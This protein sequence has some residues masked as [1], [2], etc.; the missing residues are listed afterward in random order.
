MPVRSCCTT[1][2]RPTSPT[3]LVD[4]TLRSLTAHDDSCT[5]VFQY[6]THAESRS[7]NM[8]LGR[9]VASSGDVFPRGVMVLGLEA[10]I[11]FEARQRG[12]DRQALDEKTGLP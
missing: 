6:S 12:E 3:E 4:T 2:C 8:Y 1:C 9:M 10:S 11:D 7:T 5:H